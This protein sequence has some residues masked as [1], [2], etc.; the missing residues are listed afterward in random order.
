MKLLILMMRLKRLNRIL[1]Y[2]GDREPIP[3]EAISTFMCLNKHAI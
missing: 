2:S 1:V 3:G